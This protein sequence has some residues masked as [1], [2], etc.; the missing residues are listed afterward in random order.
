MVARMN[1]EERSRGNLRDMRFSWHA[2]RAR[3]AQPRCAGRPA[4]LRN[5]RQRA[6]SSSTVFP[7]PLLQHGASSTGFR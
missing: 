3:G 6:A 5:R 1:G 4:R 7:D 2:I